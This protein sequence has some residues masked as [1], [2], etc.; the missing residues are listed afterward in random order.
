RP[1]LAIFGDSSVMFD[2]IPDRLNSKVVNFGLFSGTPVESYFFIRRL[3]GGTEQPRSVL[4]SFGRKQFGTELSIMDRFKTRVLSNGEGSEILNQARSLNDPV[5]LRTG[6][7]FDY[8]D[9]RLD[10]FLTFYGCPTYSVYALYRTIK[11]H[12]FKSQSGKDEGVLEETL[13]LKGHI[14][15]EDLGLGPFHEE[16]DRGPKGLD[17]DATLDQFVLSPVIDAYFQKTLSLLDEK[18]IPAFFICMPENEYSVPHIRPDVSKDYDAYLA[19][20]VREHKN[21]H[22]LY[23][24]RRTYSWRSFEDCGHLNKLG[25]ERFTK[26]LARILNKAKV[27]GGP[28][29]SATP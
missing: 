15:I 18:N 24:L 28:Y 7:V 9:K 27:P 6:S 20:M 25:A 16:V 3:I 2:V 14:P 19:K 23:P 13:A 29:G 5:F 26:E 1:G 4:L 17:W 8:L 11:D 10:I 21:F 22:L 12:H